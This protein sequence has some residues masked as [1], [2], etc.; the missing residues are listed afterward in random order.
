MTK[1]ILSVSPFLSKEGLISVRE[2]SKI[3]ESQGFETRI[4]EESLFGLI[5]IFF[6]RVAVIDF[7]GAPRISTLAFAKIIK[8]SSTKVFTIHERAEFLPGNNFWK[9]MMIR[10]GTYFAIKTVDDV[11]VTQRS[12]Q[13]FFRHQ[14]KFLPAYIPEGVSTFYP[15]K[16][17]TPF[18]LK[19][20]KYLAFIDKDFSIPK[21]AETS[22]RNIINPKP[23]VIVDIENLF[24]RIPGNIKSK[25]V[26]GNCTDLE[27]TGILKNCLGIVLPEPLSVIAARQ[28]ILY[29]KPIL[30]LAT[31]EHKEAL[32]TNGIFLSELKEI[33]DHI[34]DLQLNKNRQR[35]YKAA[36]QV[37]N[38][39]NWEF[40]ANEYLKVYF[41]KLNSPINIDSVFKIRLKESEGEG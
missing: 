33:K 3:Y 25:R 35:A 4:I 28:L 10:L 1:I 26:S 17:T 30:A 19:K 9:R 18:K 5:R 13:V 34:Q 6:S 32:G 23:F 22:I 37:E 14:F 39:F 29:K 27:L 21:R 20:G 36:R 15:K 12:L 16:V 38:L 8:R 31:V 7:H 40:I 11:I 41:H 2:L 24:L